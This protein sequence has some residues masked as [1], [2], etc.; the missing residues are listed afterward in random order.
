MPKPAIVASLFLVVSVLAFAGLAYPTVP[1]ST[2]RTIIQNST[3]SGNYYASHTAIQSSQYITATSVRT[4]ET[5]VGVGNWEILYDQYGN[6]VT[7]TYVPW[8]PTFT[9]TSYTLESFVAFSS[10]EEQYTVT[11]PY[12]YTSANSI[13][14]RSTNLVPAS[15]LLGLTDGVFSILAVVVIGILAILT[16]WIALKRRMTS[17]REQAMLNHFETGSHSNSVPQAESVAEIQAIKCS[18]CN[19]EVPRERI[20]CPKCGLPARS[21]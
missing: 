12:S 13:T 21:P 18:H 10:Y 11:V 5:I 15:T 4:T 6:P 7:V 9:I 17:R 1:V 14:E 16:A 3:M 19:A 8:G 2:T 20:I